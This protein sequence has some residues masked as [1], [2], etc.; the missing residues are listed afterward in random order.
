MLELR[1]FVVVVE[2]LARTHDPI[3]VFCRIGRWRQL[4]I[5]GVGAV[6]EGIWKT[7]RIIDVVGAVQHEERVIAEADV[8]IA[9]EDVAI[10]VAAFDIIFAVGVQRIDAIAVL[11]IVDV[12]AHLGVLGEGLLAI[13]T[14]GIFLERRR[15]GAL[16][17]EV[18]G[19]AR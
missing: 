4:G 18:E 9:T 16:E 7:G 17:H 14:H 12:A 3:A 2:C 15:G 13:V 11:T 6:D 1:Q 8:E 5:G 10:D 19:A